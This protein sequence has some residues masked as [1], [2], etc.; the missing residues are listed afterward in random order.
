MVKSMNDSND[1]KKFCLEH[2]G[3][4]IGGLIAIIIACTGI[5]QLLIVF[6]IIVLGIWVGNYVQKNKDKVK[7]TLKNFIDKF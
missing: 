3:A 4:I 6:A 5:Y 7:E 1:F 2:K